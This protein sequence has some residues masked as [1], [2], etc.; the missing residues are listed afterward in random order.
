MNISNNFVS[1][2]GIMIYTVFCV[3][4]E[5]SSDITYAHNM[6]DCTNYPFT[7]YKMD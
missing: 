2:F 1:R 6:R 5:V 7:G 3:Y 4:I